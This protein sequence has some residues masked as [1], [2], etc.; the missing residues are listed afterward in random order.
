MPRSSRSRSSRGGRSSSSAATRRRPLRASTPPTPRAS[1]LRAS[2]LPAL[3][4]LQLHLWA[5]R[6]SSWHLPG[7]FLRSFLRECEQCSVRPAAG[8]GRGGEDQ[9]SLVVPRFRGRCGKA[10][11]TS[12]GSPTKNR[13]LSKQTSKL[14]DHAHNGTQTNNSA[15]HVTHKPSTCTV[16]LCSTCAHVVHVTRT[17][18][19]W[20]FCITVQYIA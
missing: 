12:H 15:V 8:Q 1:L 16:L 14:F 18:T 17:C 2:L 11:W 19:T 20:L 7:I 6:A 4:S 13:L 5:G 10:T 9:A 3:P